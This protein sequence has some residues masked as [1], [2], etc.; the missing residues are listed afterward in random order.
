MSMRTTLN[1]QILFEDD[2]VRARSSVSAE[3]LSPLGKLASGAR[4]KCLVGLVAGEG[5]GPEL[6]RLARDV[7]AAIQAAS[8]RRFTFELGGLIGADAVREHGVALTDEAV[9]FFERIFARGGAVLCGPGGH[10]FVYDLRRKLDLYCKVSPIQVDDELIPVSRLR[11]DLVRGL[12]MLVVRDNA[13]GIYQG[14]WN[15]GLDGDGRRFATHSFSYA[16][17]DIRRIVGVAARLAAGRGRRLHVVA[18][19]GGVPTITDLWRDVADEV[20]REHDIEATLIDADL[21]AYQLIHSP[22]SF[23]VVVCPN[24][25]GDILGDMMAVALGS[26]GL[27]Y[28]GNFSDK[29]G[30]VYQTNHGSAYDL[31]GSDRANPVA[32]IYAL[33]MML[34]ESFGLVDEARWVRDAVRAVWRSGRKTADVAGPGD[35]IVGSSELG[36]RVADSIGQVARSAT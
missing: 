28:S 21:A 7:L 4:D 36:A 27:A 25:L 10:R 13:G 22:R 23:D 29:G 35:T 26:R 31:V 30:A 34:R 14:S 2:I 15:G 32:H 9:G 6:T 16:E 1:D 5:I 12:D 33:A 20:A 11:P 18:K 19:N 17:P 24:M 3:P 8:P